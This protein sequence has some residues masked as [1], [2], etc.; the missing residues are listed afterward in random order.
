MRNTTVPAVGSCNCCTQS[1]EGG[2]EVGAAKIS[3]E[4]DTLDLSSLLSW[5]EGRGHQPVLEPQLVLLA[6]ALATVT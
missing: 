1:S 3:K 5:Y 6:P 4:V 2:G